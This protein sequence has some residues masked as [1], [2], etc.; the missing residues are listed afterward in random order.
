MGMPS[1]CSACVSGQRLYLL[2]RAV[3]LLYS[4]LCLGATATGI[5]KILLTD[6]FNDNA[7]DV[8]DGLVCQS[9]GHAPTPVK[10]PIILFNSRSVWFQ[11]RAIIITAIFLAIFIV[12]IIGVA[13]F[14]RDHGPIPSDDDPVNS[15]AHDRIRDIFLTQK[16]PKATTR[17]TLRRRRKRGSHRKTS[18]STM[19][20]R[21]SSNRNDTHI[22]E[23]DPH[24]ETNEESH[25]MPPLVLMRGTPRETILPEEVLEPSGSV[26]TPA[27][28][29]PIPA[30]GSPPFP[31][32]ATIPTAPVP[33][34]S[35]LNETDVEAVNQI[36]IE[37][38]AAQLPSYV[39]VSRPSRPLSLKGRTHTDE[40]ALACSSASNPISTMPT[41]PSISNPDT[42]TWAA[43]VATDDKSALH[44]LHA[45]R[46]APGMPTQSL[47]IPSAP[48]WP[49]F[50]DD[51]EPGAIPGESVSTQD[52][53]SHADSSGA[54]TDTFPAP[55][56]VFEPSVSD[57][58][59]F[60]AST[61]V[62]SSKAREAAQQSSWLPTILPSRPE[63]TE[64][65]YQ[66]PSAPDMS[67]PMYEPAPSIP[68]LDLELGLGPSSPPLPTD[69][70]G[71]EHV[72]PSAP[73]F[74]E[75]S[76]IRRS[77]QV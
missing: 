58:S 32:D 38:E 64:Q 51:A 3:L 26:D 11:R 75:D 20:S 7:A 73:A 34:S 41:P 71:D 17:R 48:L 56:T 60:L 35:Q 37:Y 44:A 33:I 22:R 46:S 31:Q 39:T 27:P 42:H 45:E 2:Y 30:S 10:N 9:P 18:G 12:L 15:E 21:L 63:L 77:P 49:S 13:V 72:I 23:P 40:V 8:T 52:P 14:M 67:L 70:L 61:S 4:I 5:R 29:N 65:A 55:P 28:S 68:D 50:T 16:P 36:P 19:P 57:S 25:E 62:G 54:T 47:P 1:A 24:S 74:D 53:L 76:G 69:P 59:V 43:H 6:G 66:P